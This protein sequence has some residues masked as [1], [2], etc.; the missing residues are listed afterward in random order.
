MREM[1]LIFLLNICQFN[2]DDDD[3]STQILRIKFVLVVSYL[4][5]NTTSVNSLLCTVLPVP[6]NTGKSTFPTDN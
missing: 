5:S 1:M 4:N 3:D 6:T 2:D